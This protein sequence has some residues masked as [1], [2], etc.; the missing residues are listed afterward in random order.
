MR[1]VWIRGILA[2]VWLAAALISGGA[3][4]VIM[5]MVFL[6]SA[7]SAWKREKNGKGED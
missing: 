5:G 4:Y 3:L 1:H 2:L 6:I 7:Y